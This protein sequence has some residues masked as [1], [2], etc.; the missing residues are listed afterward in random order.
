MTR[1]LGVRRAAVEAGRRRPARRAQGCLGPATPEGARRSTLRR[2]A[3]DRRRPAAID[4]V[5]RARADH[6]HPL[7]SAAGSA[8][9]AGRV[10]D[11]SDLTFKEGDKLAFL[12]PGR[13]HRQAPDLRLRRPLLHPAPATSSPPARGARRA[14]APDARP[15]RQGRHRRRLRPQ[16]R[17]Q[18][19]AGLEGG[20]WLH[21]AGG[22][23]GRAPRAPASRC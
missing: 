23:G 21:H 10:E 8:P 7:A 11:P 3:R 6:R 13:D 20:L 1:L 12:R 16:A 19:R 4:V 22:R 5:R 17:A 18:A 9:R 14:A 2:G 15:R